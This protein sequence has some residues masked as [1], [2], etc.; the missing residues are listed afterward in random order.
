M[1]YKRILLKLSGGGLSGKTG[2]GFDVNAINHITSEIIKAKEI[3]AEISIM[4]GGGNIFRPYYA[5][6]SENMEIVYSPC[7]FSCDNRSEK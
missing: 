7:D 2:F 6:I 5:Y 4:I 1:K 3:G